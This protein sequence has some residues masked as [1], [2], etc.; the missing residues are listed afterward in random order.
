MIYLR[1]HNVE[2]SDELKKLADISSN[3][4]L[5]ISLRA[6]LRDEHVSIVSLQFDFNCIER[7]F[8]ADRSSSVSFA[9]K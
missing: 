6:K 8:L 5:A 9:V 7:T 3:E 4:E 1:S 2:N